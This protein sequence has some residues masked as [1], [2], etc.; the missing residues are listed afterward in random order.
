MNFSLYIAKRYLFAKSGNSTINLITIIA[1]LGVVISSAALFVILSG[2]SG[3]RVFNDS[4]LKT[5]DPDIK[6]S[7]VKGKSFKLTKKMISDISEYT[8]IV[9]YT[10][11]VEERVFLRNG[12]KEQIAY[13]KGVDARYNHTIEIDSVIIQGEWLDSEKLNSSVIGYGISHKLS[14]GIL[15]YDE[16]LQIQV[17]KKGTGFLGPNSFITINTR[18]VG[19]FIG[20]EE[21]QNNYIFTPYETAQHLLGYKTDEFTALEFKI[22]ENVNL[23]ELASKLQNDFGEGFKVQTKA[24]LNELFY[25]VINTENFVSYLI[26]TLI[27]IIALFNVIG[28]VIMMIIDKKSNIRTLINIGATIKDVKRVFVLHGFL[29]TFLGMFIGLIFATVL[30]LIQQEYQLFMITQTVAYPVEFQFQNLIIVILTISVLG[31]IAAKI[32]SSRIS[33]EFVGS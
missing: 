6:I 21:F 8:G 27:I 25:K 4:M 30:I 10:S 32:A 14:L 9:V 3:L 18:V 28:A 22:D 20:P 11:V 33:K 7:A 12:D 16:G 15:N 5:T 17:P 31:F 2:F 29:L 24:Q 13:I 1:A 19:I 26:F 23:D